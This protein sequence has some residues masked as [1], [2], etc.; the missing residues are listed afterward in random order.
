MDCE[1]YGTRKNHMCP[2]LKYSLHV[3]LQDWI[4]TRNLY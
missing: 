3:K 2:V 4:M 1:V